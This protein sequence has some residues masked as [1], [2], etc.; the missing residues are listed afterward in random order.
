MFPTK[1]YYKESEIRTLINNEKLRK[2][3]TNISSF[4]KIVRNLLQESK[5]AKKNGEQRNKEAFKLNITKSGLYKIIFK[6]LLYGVTKRDRPKIEKNNMCI[7][8]R[9]WF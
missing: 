9:R 3:T 7:I 2:F 8:L 6:Y 1:L 5:D 4:N